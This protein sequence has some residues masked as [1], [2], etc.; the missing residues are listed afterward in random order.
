MT[1]NMIKW[2]HLA[3]IV[4]IAV[5]DAHPRGHA[6]TAVVV[7]RHFMDFM[8]PETMFFVSLLKRFCINL[9]DDLEHNELWY[10]YVHNIAWKMSMDDT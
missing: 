1:G 2:Q 6:G 4:N 9:C 8:G 10:N 5:S 3:Q 7:G